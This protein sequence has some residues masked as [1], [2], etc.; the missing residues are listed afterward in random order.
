MK[1]CAAE[2]YIARVEC[3]NEKCRLFIE[4]EED[5]NCTLVALE[6]HGP[7]TLEEIG[8]RHHISTVRAKQILDATLVKLK[9]T[10]VKENTI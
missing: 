10:L 1:K 6:K 8:K 9:K 2:C 5:L 3:Q 7:M 4:Y